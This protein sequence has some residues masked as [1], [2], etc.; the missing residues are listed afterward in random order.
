MV[1]SI[2]FD[3][4]LTTVYTEDET[5]W[6]SYN[7]LVAF[8]IGPHKWVCENQWGTTTGKHLNMIDKGEKVNRLPYNKF[9]AKYNELKPRKYLAV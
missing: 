6:F 2:Q 8:R 5:F 9:L 1:P 4:K 3:G 7:A